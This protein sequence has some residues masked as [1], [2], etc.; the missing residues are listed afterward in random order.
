MRTII[1]GS[2]TLCLSD[3]E[4]AMSECGWLP[5]VV[6]SGTAGGVDKAGE[7][8]AKAR[9]IPVEQYPA[10]WQRYG[11]ASGFVRNSQ[12]VKVAEAGV[13]VWDGVS[14]GV[15]QCCKEATRKGL[16]VFLTQ[17]E[18]KPKVKRVR[19]ITGKLD[20]NM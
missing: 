5:T 11:K 4:K 15:M 6:I 20:D 9:G 16:R 3:V 14:K 12:M 1:A 10:N 18:P 8:W 17:A 7:I 13:F 19:A 2:R